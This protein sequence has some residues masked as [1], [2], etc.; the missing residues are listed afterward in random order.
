MNSPRCNAAQNTCTFSLIMCLKNLAT[1][2]PHSQRCCNHCKNPRIPLRAYENNQIRSVAKATPSAAAA[3]RRPRTEV[4]PAV[5]EQPK[6]V[7]KTGV[8]NPVKNATCENFPYWHQDVA[9]GVVAV[10][11]EH[12]TQ[13]GVERGTDP[14]DQLEQMRQEPLHVVVVV[15][16]RQPAG[17]DAVA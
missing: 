5:A 13:S 4:S 16:D 6:R 12:L 2:T 1:N 15:I 8:K 9:G 11:I 10:L 17:R 3:V 14:P 7:S